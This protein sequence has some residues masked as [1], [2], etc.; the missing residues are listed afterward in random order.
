MT[1]NDQMTGD[2]GIHEQ[3]SATTE[4]RG[5]RQRAARS[6]A[7]KLMETIRNAH[8]ALED[9]VDGRGGVPR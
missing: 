6:S 5:S 2:T 8:L 9:C 4:Q 7:A 3:P 1:E